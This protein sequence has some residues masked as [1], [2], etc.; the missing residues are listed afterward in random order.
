[1]PTAPPRPRAAG[2]AARQAPSSRPA[3]RRRPP[4]PAALTARRLR[5]GRVL[6][7]TVLAIA[8]LKLVVVQTVEAGELRAASGAEATGEDPNA[9][10]R[11][12]TSDRGYVVLAKLVTPDVAR[13]LR[14]R[15]PEI[16]EERREDRQYPGGTL[17]ANVI[18]A[19]TWNADERKLTGRVGLESSQDN[20][21]AGFD[22]LRV[23]DTAE[24]SSAVIPGSTRFERAAVQGSDL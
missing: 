14:D 3:A 13:A 8:T 17:A 10:T 21:L 4:D 11:L 16:A 20:L 22:G 23:V 19:A 7:V 9:L 12:L 18:G 2:A 5:I 24:D 1:M 6:L 15:F